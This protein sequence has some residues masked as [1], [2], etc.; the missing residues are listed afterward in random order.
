MTMVVIE[1]FVGWLA[2]GGGC[3]AAA[4]VT[5]T[6]PAQLLL[7]Y[8]LGLSRWGVAALHVAVALAQLCR[9]GP[10]WAAIAVAV[11]EEIAAR[12]RRR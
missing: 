1:A 2:G 6:L 4:C 3:A 7:G 9:Q 12:G 8:V 10:L 5:M 11:K